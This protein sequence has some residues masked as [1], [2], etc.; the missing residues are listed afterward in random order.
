MPLFNMRQS[1]QDDKA[2][3]LAII[4]GL[5]K[6]HRNTLENKLEQYKE[7]DDYGKILVNEGFINEVVYFSD[8]VVL[9]ELE[10]CIE[11][12]KTKYKDVALI[13]WEVTAIADKEN[14]PMD[15]SYED[16]EQTIVN[17]LLSATNIIEEDSIT[18]GYLRRI[19]NGDT[20]VYS[21]LKSLGDILMRISM[22]EPYFGEK[23]E[24]A[25]P[26]DVSRFTASVFMIF[27]VMYNN[28]ARANPKRPHPVAFTDNDP[29]K[30]EE[31][32]KALL[33]NEG[34]N[35]KRTKGSGDFG[36]DVIASRKGVTYA[37]QCK[38]YN[39]TVGAKAVQEIAV[40][41]IHYGTDFAIVVS[42]NSYT[43]AAKSLAQSTGVIL[44]HHN[45]LIHKIETLENNTM[46]SHSNDTPDRLKTSQM[47]TEQVKNTAKAKKQ[48]TQ[49]DT[50]ELI[51]I[52]LPTI[53]ND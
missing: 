25:Q 12:G 53:K 48:W 40:G 31:Y 26:K 45:D 35:A 23:I 14:M 49:D 21:D 10:R 7:H 42:D 43:N 15:I 6:K 34:F 32:I 5:I 9:P 33:M 17:K 2:I 16:S 46:E 52:V 30:Y 24:A 50:D 8:R 3:F 22:T 29:Y 27:S 11:D 1:L 36:V 41:R 47:P 28:H 19:N 18:D 4:V 39:H 51:T 44:A 38:L 20:T 13:L 37:I